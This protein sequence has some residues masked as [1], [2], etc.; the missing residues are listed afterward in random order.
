[1]PRYLLGA[2]DMATMIAYLKQLSNDF[3]PGATEK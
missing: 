2:A 1:M 3:S